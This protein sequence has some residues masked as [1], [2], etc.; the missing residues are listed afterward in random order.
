MSSGNR[1]EPALRP[2]QEDRADLARGEVLDGGQAQP[3]LAGRDAGEVGEPHRVRAR[4]GRPLS[5]PPTACRILPLSS[6]RSAA[7]PLCSAANRRRFRISILRS[8]CWQ[9]P[10]HGGVHPA[11]AGSTCTRRPPNLSRRLWA[12]KDSNIRRLRPL[13]GNDRPDSRAVRSICRGRE[14]PCGADDERRALVIMPA[15]APS[16]AW[17]PAPFPRTLPAR[18]PQRERDAM[19]I[20]GRRAERRGGGASL[21]GVPAARRSRSSSSSRRARARSWCGSARRAFAIPTS[22]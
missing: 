9:A 19:K 4:S 5:S 11:G 1:P 16:S 12:H 7:S 17:A 22:R 15:A 2:A 13:Y 10:P 6:G 21:R 20:Q 18:T 8:R 14:R 3:A